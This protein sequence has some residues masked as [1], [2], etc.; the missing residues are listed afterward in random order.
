MKFTL[1]NIR[2]H[3][4]ELAFERYFSDDNSPV[5]TLFDV[6]GNQAEEFGSA[7][8]N[9]QEILETIKE[10]NHNLKVEEPVKE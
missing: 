5:I 8:L 9:E 3:N 2:Y 4:Q 1:P 7:N 6:E 10:V